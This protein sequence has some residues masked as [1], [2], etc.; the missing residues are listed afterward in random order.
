VS[1][2]PNPLLSTET[3]LMELIALAGQAG[4]QPAALELLMDDVL[5]RTALV[6]AHGVSWLEIVAT[7]PKFDGPAP[8]YGALGGRRF[9]HR[10]GLARRGRFL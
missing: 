1:Q 4:E 9:H 10:A 5:T 8:A 3:M 2:D 6:S 7:L